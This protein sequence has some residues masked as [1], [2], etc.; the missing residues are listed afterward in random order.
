MTEA[1]AKRS[2]PLS[3]ENRARAYERA[4]Q[5]TLVRAAAT[6]FIWIFAFGAYLAG[7]IQEKHITGIGLSVLFLLFINLPSLMI[8]RRAANLKTFEFVTYLFNLIE[9][10]G[11]TAVI[12][13]LGGIKALYLS[14]IYA[15]LISYLGV[16]APPRFPFLVAAFSSLALGTTALL[17]YLGVLPSFDL[18]HTPPYPLW[19]QWAIILAV[20]ATFFVVAFLTSTV[21]RQ[22]RRSR[23]QLRYQYT[24]LSEKTRQLRQTEQ[25]LR[26]IKEELE[27]R[28]EERTA[29]L[30]QSVA[31]LRDEIQERVK[32]EEELRKNEARFRRIVES[33][34]LPMGLINP[35]GGVEY[36]NPQFTET[37]GFTAATVPSLAEWF[38]SSSRPASSLADLFQRWRTVME[39]TA[40]ALFSPVVFE[41]DLTCKDGSV[42]TVEIRG[43]LMGE[44]ILTVF[45][46]LTERKAAEEERRRLEGQLREVQKL[47]SLG[48]LAGGI[49]HDFNNLLLAILGNAD[50]ALLSLPNPSPARA[51]L[52]DIVRASKRAADLCQQMLAY[53][54]KGQFQVGLYD[55]SEIVRDIAQMIEVSISKKAVLRYVFPQDLPPVKV[56][57]TQMQQVIMNLITNASEALGDQEGQI[58]VST[59][60]QHCDQAYLAHSCAPNDLPPGLYVY[61]EVS[62]TGCGM[63]Q[64]TQQRIFDPFFTTKFT[65]RGLGLAAVLGIVRGHGGAIQVYSEPGKGTRFKVL[66]P[67]QE[68]KGLPLTSSAPDLEDF[69]GGGTILLVD[70]DL[71]ICQVGGTMLEQLGFQVLTAHNGS[72][73]LKVFRERMEEIRCVILDLTMPGLDGDETF[74]RLHRLNPHVP[75]ILSSG[76]NE[77][78]VY[79]KFNGAGPAGFLQKPYTLA[80]LKE[81]LARVL[82][83]DPRPV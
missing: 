40:P 22:V 37:F 71:L 27:N 33:S 28:V 56:D 11:Y 49:A 25:E 13:F 77:Q 50:L 68:G 61:L 19:N 39:E 17:E 54:G 64:E 4:K 47:E 53:S 65:G 7:V 2:E 58:T 78:E 57:A 23:E 3:P 34:P 48:I 69:K 30:Q 70:D 10:I 45:N 79:R 20:S 74:R 75:V 5:G 67:A 9:V 43:A 52:E 66:L 12:Y 72:E 1:A 36:V 8:Y 21:T 59:G 32:A 42:R 44:R 76:Y 6:V 80:A 51:Y 24:M 83:E 31:R 46:D 15:I 60:V 38:R 81:V 82:Q 41:A 62:D 26:K 18:H 63:D 14:P 16:M 35:E 55:L 73:G 29:E